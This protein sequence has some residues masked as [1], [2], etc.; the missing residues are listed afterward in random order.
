MFLEMSDNAAAPPAIKTREP[1][2]DDI[3]ESARKDLESSRELTRETAELHGENPQQQRVGVTVDLGH[4]QLVTLPDEIIDIIKDEI[5]RCL[6]HYRANK[7][8]LMLMS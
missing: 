8:R 2:K 4:K 6:N 7:E 3:I 5:E 1:S